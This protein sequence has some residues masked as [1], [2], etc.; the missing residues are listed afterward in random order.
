M[1]S[2]PLINYCVSWSFHGYRIYKWKSSFPGE[3][4]LR[5]SD[6]NALVHVTSAIAITLF[7]TLKCL[8][9]C[10]KITFQREPRSSVE[11]RTNPKTM[12]KG[13][14]YLHRIYTQSQ[15]RTW[16]ALNSYANENYSKSMPTNPDKWEGPHATNIHRLR[17]YM[18]HAII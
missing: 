14:H 4:T 1:V 11:N 2:S 8:D 3:L 15:G 9:S 10:M 6:Y 12:A 5:P 17:S 18:P 13:W 7:T 16:R